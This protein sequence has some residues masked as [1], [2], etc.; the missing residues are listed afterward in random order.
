MSPQEINNSRVII[1]PPKGLASAPKWIMSEVRAERQ[2][3][4]DLAIGCGRSTRRR[5]PA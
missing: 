4:N 5:V 3:K 2:P 1:G